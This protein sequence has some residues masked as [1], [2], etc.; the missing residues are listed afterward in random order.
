MRRDKAAKYLLLA[1]KQAQL[2]SKDPST[3]VGAILLAPES[4]QVLS[5][6]YNGMPRGIDENVEARWARPAKYKF[7]EHAERNALYNACRHGTPLQ[8]CIAVITMFPCCDCA[9]ALIQSGVRTV[10]APPAD[11]ADARWGGDFAV[12]LE[13]FAEAGVETIEVCDDDLRHFDDG[14]HA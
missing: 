10:V 11:M 7:V 1:R 3:K 13:M 4:L 2:F 9:R 14:I 12:S 8:G 5:V 6:G